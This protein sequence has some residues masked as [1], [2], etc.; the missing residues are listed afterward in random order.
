MTVLG[1][2]LHATGQYDEAVEVLLPAMKLLGREFPSSM[3]Q[4][5]ATV[6]GFICQDLTVFRHLKSKKK[7]LRRIQ[8]P[9]SDLS[10]KKARQARISFDRLRA[11]GALFAVFYLHPEKYGPIDFVVSVILMKDE[12]EKAYSPGALSQGYG[13][14][15]V[16]F[17]AL[18]MKSLALRYN[19]AAKEL[20][21][22]VGSTE[23]KASAAYCSIYVEGTQ[24]NYEQARAEALEGRGLYSIL[25]VS[26]RERECLNMWSG[27]S[28]QQGNFR[29]ALS[30]LFPSLEI[31]RDASDSGMMASAL[32][33]IADCYFYLAEFDEV[34]RINEDLRALGTWTTPN[35]AHAYVRE[36]KEGAARAERA[37]RSARAQEVRERSGRK[38]VRERSGR[39]K[40]ASEAG[41]KK[42][43]SEAGAKKCVSEAGAKKCVGEEGA[44]KR[45][46]EAG[47]K[48]CVSEEGAKK[49]RLHP[50]HRSS[51][52]QKRASASALSTLAHAEKCWSL[53]ARAK[54]SNMPGVSC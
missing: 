26:R 38:E 15:C 28:V 6:T 54:D 18:G 30:N 34:L 24:G 29:L 44:K 37:Q 43:T 47:A 49:K 17:T 21:E 23:C 4:K 48:K 13:Y 25:G 52:A 10:E 40:C 3:A 1:L 35:V 42:C 5:L 7:L 31:Q 50:P 9:L 51:H 22:I 2:G 12:A 41:A 46:S 39:K 45:V 36:R 14:L 53:G 32:G 8:T 11:L 20:A 16:T 33:P 19:L 27:I